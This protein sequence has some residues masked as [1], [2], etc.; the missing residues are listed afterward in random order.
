VSTI[1]L[2]ERRTHNKCGTTQILVRRIHVDLLEAQIATS[3]IVTRQCE[4][5]ISQGAQRQSHC[6]RA[7]KLPR[8]GVGSSAE[9]MER[10]VPLRV[11]AVHAGLVLGA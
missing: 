5:A 11:Y 8:E 3:K 9:R 10:L 1:W 2:A 4:R 6:R 7:H